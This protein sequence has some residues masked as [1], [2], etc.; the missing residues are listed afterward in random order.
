MP[1]FCT[2]DAD[3][4]APR[5][6]RARPTANPARP[7]VR[8]DERIDGIDFPP[9]GVNGG[10]EGG[11]GH[12]VINPGRADQR[13]VAPISDGTVIRQPRLWGW[14]YKRVIGQPPLLMR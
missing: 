10:R 11:A 1:D 5:R 14:H 8:V 3:W 9:W 13:T 12:C 4:R 7:I 2:P 6:T